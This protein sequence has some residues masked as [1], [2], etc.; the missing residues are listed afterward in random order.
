MCGGK[1][2]GPWPALLYLVLDRRADMATGT[3]LPGR[4][5]R[6]LAAPLFGA[7]ARRVRVERDNLLA[8]RHQA[9]S[10]ITDGEPGRR[11]RRG[12]RRGARNGGR[13][14]PSIATARICITRRYK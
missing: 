7:I 13:R 1:L 11:Q 5:A 8:A 10:K 14:P 12:R 2:P 9:L 6:G 3:F 4:V